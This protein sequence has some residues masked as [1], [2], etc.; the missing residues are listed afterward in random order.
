MC[1]AKKGSNS[2]FHR[3]LVLEST[4]ASQLMLT[5]L[6]E[7]YFLKVL[8]QRIHDKKKVNKTNLV[9]VLLM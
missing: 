2:F 1:I 8:P 4:I 9:R 6:T 5:F 7:K 3:N